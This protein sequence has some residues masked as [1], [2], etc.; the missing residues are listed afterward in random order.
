MTHRRYSD[1]SNNQAPDWSGGPAGPILPL[2]YPP[3][4]TI[5]PPGRIQTPIRVGRLHRPE[6]GFAGW[7]V[8]RSEQPYLLSLLA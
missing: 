5:S 4:Q 3:A 6:F 8:K 2:T 7:A 1:G